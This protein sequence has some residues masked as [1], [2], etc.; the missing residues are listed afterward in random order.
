[1]RAT[2]TNIGLSDIVNDIRKLEK[3]ELSSVIYEDFNEQYHF[4]FYI[5]IALLLLEM[6]VL[7]R[8]GRWRLFKE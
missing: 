6:L 5:A 2:T 7:E 4:L 1:V 8:R 3:Q